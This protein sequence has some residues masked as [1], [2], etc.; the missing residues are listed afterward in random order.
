MFYNSVF[1][2]IYIKWVVNLDFC[3]KYLVSAVSRNIKNPE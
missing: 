3:T 1:N 2:F